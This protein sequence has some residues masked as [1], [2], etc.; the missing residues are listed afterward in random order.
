MD[1]TLRGVCAAGG[2][3]RSKIAAF[4]REVHLG[5]AGRAG[6]PVARLLAG[7]PERLKIVRFLA[8]GPQNVTAT[9][10]TLGLKDKSVVNVSRHPIALTHAN[11]IATRNRGGSCSTRCGRGCWR[12]RARP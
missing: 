6:R 7:G 4:G 9:A 5:T 1:R 12:T 11:L 10:D 3:H 8:D 2:G